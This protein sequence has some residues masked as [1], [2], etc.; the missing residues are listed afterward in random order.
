VNGNYTETGTG[1]LEVQLGGSSASGQFGRL[2]VNGAATGGGTL[3]VSLVNG[4]S[5]TTGDSL[6][7]SHL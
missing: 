4:Y 5:G 6:C 2:I 3:T 1:T 7:H